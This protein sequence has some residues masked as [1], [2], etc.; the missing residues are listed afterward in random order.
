MRQWSCELDILPKADPVIDP[1][2]F[3]LRRLV[4]P[5]RPAAMGRAIDDIEELHAVR[6]AEISI[7][8]WHGTEQIHAHL[9]PRK[10]PVALDLKRPIAVCNRLAAPYGF[11]LTILSYPHR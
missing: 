5:R 9:L 4:G 6:A 11:H 10:I 7:G 8:L 2:H 3:G 1:A